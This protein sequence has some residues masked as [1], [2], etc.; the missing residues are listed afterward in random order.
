MEP[1]PSRAQ[2]LRG[3]VKTARPGSHEGVSGAGDPLEQEPSLH[4][5]PIWNFPP[6]PGIGEH[7]AGC[8]MFKRSGSVLIW[9]YLFCSVVF[10]VPPGRA[11]RAQI[12]FVTL[13][14]FMLICSATAPWALI[15]RHLNTTSF[16]DFV[17]ICHINIVEVLLWFFEKA[18]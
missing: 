18:H 10:C 12:H 14:G 3:G 7:A 13:K 9:F 16:I 15:R 8:F 4:P 2:R 1:A 17:F 11:A 5:L 6:S